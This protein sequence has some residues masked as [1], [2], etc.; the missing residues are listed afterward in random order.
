MSGRGEALEILRRVDEGAFAAP[1]LERAG[2]DARDANFLRTVVLGVLRWRLRLDYVIEKLAG[3]RVSKIDPIALQ[4]L[5]VGMYQIMFME[6]PSYAAVSETVSLAA[7]RAPR[8]KGFVNAVLREATRSDLTALLPDEPEGSLYRLSIEFAHP[9]WLVERWAETYGST[10]TRSILKSNQQLSHP[11]LLVNR[12]QITPDE[13]SALLSEQGVA[14]QDSPLVEG[15]LRI[16]GSTAPLRAGLERGVF[17]PMDE[18]SALV[19]SLFGVPDGRLLDVAAAPG[20]K[21]LLLTMNGARVTSNDVSLRRLS[22]LRRSHAAMFGE[23]PQI[24]VSDGRKPAFRVGAFNSIL[25]DAP[26]SATGTI[27]KNPEIKWR[28]SPDDLSQFARL[29]RELLAS[30]LDLTPSRLLYSTCSL[31]AEENDHVIR[32]V[33]D[34]YPVYRQEELTAAQAPG[35]ADWIQQGVLRLTPESGADGF[36]AFMLTRKQT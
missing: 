31:E 3:R 14:H 11:D 30:C 34:G 1:L 9:L 13:A 4:L 5:R 17:H 28:L 33:L 25:L 35:A 23:A 2:G 22:V 6:V 10:R 27:R 16:E 15:M 8:A 7:R 36:T 29:Q 19:A 32:E 20:G 12:R 26:C 24:V 21:S 18:G